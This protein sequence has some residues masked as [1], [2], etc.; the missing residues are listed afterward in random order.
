L[1]VDFTGDAG[2]SWKAAR[3]GALEAA[4]PT[5]ERLKTETDRTNGSMRKNRKEKEKKDQIKFG[6]NASPN[7]SNGPFANISNSGRRELFES[8]LTNKTTGPERLRE[9]G[10]LCLGKAKQTAGSKGENGSNEEC[11]HKSD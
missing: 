1:A 6:S 4:G 8:R 10:L 5:A 7:R 2:V 9:K 11:L 3:K